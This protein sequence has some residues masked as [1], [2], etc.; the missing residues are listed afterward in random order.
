MLEVSEGVGWPEFLLQFLASDQFSG[1]E[2]QGFE[3]L[4]RLA[5]QTDADALLAQ[6]G[7]LE[8]H[9]EDAEADDSR[10]LF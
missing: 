6:F 8:I 4:K 1:A 9:L 10:C 7:G 3:H 2:D 5:G